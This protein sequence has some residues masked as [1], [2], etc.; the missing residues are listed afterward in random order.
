VE[1]GKQLGNDVLARIGAKQ[2]A[3]ELDASSNALINLFR[4]GKI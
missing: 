3:T 4:Q 1:L 2:D